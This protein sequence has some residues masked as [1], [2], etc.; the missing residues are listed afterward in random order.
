[1]KCKATLLVHI[2]DEEEER[3]NTIKEIRTSND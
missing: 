3:K 1:M 2:R